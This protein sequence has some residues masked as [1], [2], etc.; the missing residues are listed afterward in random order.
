M[1]RFFETLVDTY[2]TAEPSTPPRRL[3]PFVM[4][5]A[6][7]VMPWLLLMSLLTAL[8]SIAEVVFFSYLGTLVDILG[9]ADRATFL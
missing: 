6:R 9:T 3:F 2:P 4:H 5:Y 8:I 1:F 7:P